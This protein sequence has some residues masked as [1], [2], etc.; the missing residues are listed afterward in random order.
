MAV[1]HDK[2]EGS[3][4]NCWKLYFDGTSNTLGYDISVVLITL[5]GKYCPFTARLDINSTNNMAKYKACVMGL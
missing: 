4:K 5:D 1:S 3:K 2:G